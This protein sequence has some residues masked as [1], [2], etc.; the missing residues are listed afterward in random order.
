MRAQSESAAKQVRHF[1]G[2]DNVL[3][4]NPT[5]PT[6]AVA[7]DNVDIQTLSGLAGHVSRDVSP[8]V[9]RVFCDHR[10]P[11]Y[12]PCHPTGEE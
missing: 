8:A 9:H 2:K 6:G 3:R 5:V 7:L 12:T 10:A 4:L 11:A 1:I